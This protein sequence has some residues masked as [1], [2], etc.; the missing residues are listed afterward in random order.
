MALDP[1]DHSV[2]PIFRQGLSATTKTV[3]LGFL[4]VLLMAADHRLQISQPI[5]SGVAVV[6]APFQWLSLQPGRA[7]GLSLIHI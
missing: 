1:L 5:R 2:P 7:V 6:L 3:L 4:A